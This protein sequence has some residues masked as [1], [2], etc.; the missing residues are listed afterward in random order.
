MEDGPARWQLS[1]VKN[2]YASHT[3][4]H[5]HTHTPQ[6]NQQIQDTNQPAKKDDH[7]NAH[8]TK[9][10]DSPS[11]SSRM[12]PKRMKRLVQNARDKDKAN[13]RNYVAGTFIT[14]PAIER[15]LIEQEDKCLFCTG[16]FDHDASD[17]VW[18]D[19]PTLDRLDWACAF[20]VDNVIMV[21]HHCHT[22]RGKRTV[23]EMKEYGMCLKLGWI[24][25]CCECRI[26]YGDEA[27]AFNKSTSARDGLQPRCKSCTAARHSARRSSKKQQAQLDRE[28]ANPTLTLDQMQVMVQA[29]RGSD[30]KHDRE[31][32]EADFITVE[33]I[34]QLLV[35]Q[36][37][38][39]VYCADMF[40]H[41]AP[42]RQHPSAPTVERIN[43]ELAHTINNCVLACAYCNCARQ[44]KSYEE[45][46]AKATDMKTGAIKYCSDCDTWFSRAEN[47][48]SNNK[49]EHDGQQTICKSCSITRNK[50][51]RS[52][53]Q[54]PRPETL[55][56]EDE[57]LIN[58]AQPEKPQADT[59]AVAMKPAEE[60]KET[61]RCSRC[62]TTYDDIAS[63]FYKDR[64]RN[65]G[66]HPVCR[67]CTRARARLSRAAQDLKHP[68]RAQDAARIAAEQV[69]SGYHDPYPVRFY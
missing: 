13:K 29:S 32:K 6:D 36:L 67:P 46:L 40:D 11:F 37:D 61:K 22:T 62:S 28:S 18:P 4:T 34:E 1:L 64:R 10:S 51:Y 7:D 57:P 43:E 45:M 55:T 68:T 50:A 65:D 21:C 53:K 66:L 42:T 69:A 27:D 12:L 47:A 14:I 48:F 58:A 17:T 49:R 3:H 23:A 25:Q 60:T 59:P 41:A 8:R 54:S 20:T 38:R 52:T 44:H 56:K 63:S 16:P 30:K 39:C 19:T 2:T 31:Y 15:L 9:P 26:F 5:T 24:K 35:N 33:A